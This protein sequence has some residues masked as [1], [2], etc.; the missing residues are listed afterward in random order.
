MAEKRIGLIPYAR[1]GA[2]GGN[3]NE[4]TC[5]ILVTD[6]RTIIAFRKPRMSLRQGFKD[7]VGKEAN[8]PVEEP[9]AIDLGKIDLD[10]LVAMND[11]LT[12]THLSV[13]KF[14]LGRMMGSYLLIMEYRD[15]D[16]KQK[17][18]LATITP[19]KELIRRKKSEGI[20]PKETRRQYAAKSQE[21]F[22]KALPPLIAQNAEWKL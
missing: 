16:Q 20:K 4:E 11:N 15:S 14:S 22:K 17:S 7:L 1:T 10:S 12:I 6:R 18:I 5:S 9:I 21:V 2:R 13:E 19:P 8:A 3:E